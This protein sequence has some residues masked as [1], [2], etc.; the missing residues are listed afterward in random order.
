ME[1]DLAMYLCV[2][3]IVVLMG[4]PATVPTLRLCLCRWAFEAIVLAAG[5]LPDAE[6]SLAVVGV[7]LNIGNWLF[8]LPNG[9]G[10]EWIA[11]LTT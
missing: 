2:L 6:L 8:A 3:F 1:T 10:S 9:L 5:L 11:G 4:W 7:L